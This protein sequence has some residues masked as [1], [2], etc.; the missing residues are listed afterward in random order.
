MRDISIDRIMTTRPATVG[1]GDPISTAKTLL[2]PGDIHHLPVV[3]E[4]KL[5]GIVSSSDLLKFEL[6]GRDA[7][8]L[9]GA[10]ISQAMVA[11]PVVLESGANLRD[12][13]KK[14]SVGGFHALPVVDSDRAL[15]GIVTS[16]DLI[17]HLL[18]Q[19]PS[20]DGSLRQDSGTKSAVEV[21]DHEIMVVLHEAK[22]IAQRDG[23]ENRMANVLLHT[24]N[25]NRLL[26]EAC[27][28]AELYIRSGHGEH[29]HSVL[30]KRLAD[31]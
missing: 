6:L 30:V 4:N 9:S 26:H 3:E 13:A 18:Q 8:F 20:G 27:K 24:R 21:D 25:R 23:R 19:I 7:A 28:A 14:L 17:T 29:E 1:P 2:D 10:T 16:S 15:V 5:V 22:E 12:A 11:D 31:L